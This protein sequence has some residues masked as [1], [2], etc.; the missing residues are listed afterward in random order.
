MMPDRI[1]DVEFGSV[2]LIADRAAGTFGTPPAVVTW[3][4]WTGDGKMLFED[5]TGN[6][7]WYEQVDLSELTIDSRTFQPIGVNVQRPWNG[8]EGNDSNFM[9][10]T[11]PVELLYVFSNAL[12]NAQI[13][14]G[15]VDLRTFR[16]LGLDSSDAYR[17]SDL[18]VI[19]DGSNTIYA[20]ETKY[21]NSIANSI[22]TWNGFANTD[23]YPDGDF[24]QPLLCAD[25]SVAEVNTWGEMR[26]ILGPVLHCYRVILHETQNL[27][28]L[29]TA[30][31]LVVAAG[32]TNRKFSPISLKILCKEEKLSEGEYL[33]EASNAYNNS[34]WDTPSDV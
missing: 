7:I 6:A 12:P 15:L 27:N 33:V 28:G 25:M 18:A 9:P 3:E 16:D 31:S 11:R 14:A 19:P 1:F 17:T 30:N 20:Q 24:Y 23:P 32:H 10:S 5:G 29:G 8:P 4:T 34:N 26:S 13:E 22:N 2:Q 21:F